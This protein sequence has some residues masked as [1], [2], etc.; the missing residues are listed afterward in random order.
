[1]PSDSKEFH[2][3][4]KRD[5]LTQLEKELS[6]LVQTTS[7]PEKTPFLQNEMNRFASLFNHFLQEDGP[8]VDWNRIEKLPAD[9]VKDYSSLQLPTE[10]QHIRR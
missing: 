9:A 7:E 3:V 6:N 10:N 5:A 2:E 1:M 8:S 4:T